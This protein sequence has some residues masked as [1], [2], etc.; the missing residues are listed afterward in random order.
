MFL[1]T[2]NPAMMIIV[3]EIRHLRV[4]NVGLWQLRLSQSPTFSAHSSQ[5]L[6][7]LKHSLQYPMPRQS[8][9]AC[10]LFTCPIFSKIII[11][12][13]N[14]NV[15]PIQY[16]DESVAVHIPYL[17]CGTEASLVP[18]SILFCL[19]SVIG[20]PLIPGERPHAQVVLC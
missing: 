10:Q 14:T 2:V 1:L 15:F 5:T 13:H 18:A 4:R 12:S 20:A 9:S 7:S 19:S 6:N 3:N 11:R 16:G 17:G 8:V